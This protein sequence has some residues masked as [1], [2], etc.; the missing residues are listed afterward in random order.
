M[1]LGFLGDVW[2]STYLEA[3]D[4]YTNGLAIVPD[5]EG[6]IYV[7]GLTRRLSLAHP[8]SS[9]PRRLVFSRS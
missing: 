5:K 4:G 3:H 8:P 9:R 6:N 1:K 7:S 2:Y